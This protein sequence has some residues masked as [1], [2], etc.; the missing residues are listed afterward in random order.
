VYRC[1]KYAYYLT[2]FACVAV[3]LLAAAK[4]LCAVVKL[5]TPSDHYYLSLI[6][7]Y[8][9]TKMCPD[10]SILGTSNSGRREYHFCKVVNCCSKVVYW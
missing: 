6:W 9:D 1:S 5:Y 3:K 8:L 10:T 2:R 4:L 7:M